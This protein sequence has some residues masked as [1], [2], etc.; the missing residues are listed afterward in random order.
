MKKP[1]SFVSRAL[2][3]MPKTVKD[4]KTVKKA[5]EK[6]Q[7]G[8]DPEVSELDAEVSEPAVQKKSSLKEEDFALVACGGL[9]SKLDRLRDSTR[10]L[11]IEVTDGPFKKFFENLSNKERLEM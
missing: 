2:G 4:P 5:A 11:E 3:K 10:G 6:K 8:P 9:Q 1:A 7:T